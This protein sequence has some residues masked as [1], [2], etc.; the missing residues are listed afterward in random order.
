[1]TQRLSTQVYSVPSKHHDT[2]I[3]SEVWNTTTK[4]N[5]E[6][7]QLFTETTHTVLGHPLVIEGCAELHQQNNVLFMYNFEGKQFFNS[8]E[9]QFTTINLTPYS[10]TY[11]EICSLLRSAD[12]AKIYGM[13]ATD[14]TEP[15][16]VT[17]KVQEGENLPITD[18][19]LT[20]D[21]PPELK[22]RYDDGKMDIHIDQ[23]DL[24]N[25]TTTETF[26]SFV[27]LLNQ[28][29]LS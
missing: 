27:S 24:E 18:A 19:F 17:Q 11:T 3:N 10:P 4:P 2:I 15:T 9:S 20:W 7:Y 8:I 14:K 25:I 22:V 21:N 1:M 6:T 5:S 29:F 28:H 13:T 26:T 16:E 12:S 23:T